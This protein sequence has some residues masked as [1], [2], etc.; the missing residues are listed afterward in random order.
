M[1][2]LPSRDSAQAAPRPGTSSL[3]LATA[4]PD[5][6]PPLA[7]DARADVAVVGAGMAGLVAAYLLAKAGRSVVVLDRF[8]VA[9]GESGH[10]TAHLTRVV[11]TR[12]RDLVRIH[13][14]EAAR[15]AWDG[16]A[17]ATDLVERIAAE[18][19]IACGFVR[20][21]GYLVGV[22]RDDD[23]ILAEEATWARRFG[24]DVEPADPSALPFQG[25][26]VLQFPGQARFHP[27]AFLRGLAR[28]IL[29]LGGRI[30]VGVEVRG[31][32]ASEAGEGLRVRTAQGPTVQAGAVVVASNVPFLDRIGMNP[33]LFPYRSYAIAARVPRGALA[34][35]LVWT[36]SEPGDVYGAYHYLRLEPSGGEDLAILGGEDHKV[37]HAA[38]PEEAWQRLEQRLRR[39]A[40]VPLRVEHRWSGQIIE[41]PDGLPYIGAYPGDPEDVWVATAFSGN[42]MTF[43]ALAGHILAERI[44]G[45]ATAWD[46]AF[47]P[48]RVRGDLGA[49]LEENLD[50]VGGLAR[51]VL[52]ASGAEGPLAPGEGAV[53]SVGGRKVAAYRTPAGELQ[54]CSAVCTHMGCTVAFNRAEGTFDCPCHGSRFAPGGEVLNG[55]A[56]TPLEPVAAAEVEAA[57]QKSRPAGSRGGR[58]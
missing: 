57:L 48:G 39:E 17:F 38:D 37:G 1:A 23:R 18:E 29:A 41:N 3:W 8:G 58:D 26:A 46:E 40:G 14:E 52:P 36:T 13:G 6:Y 11:D 10:T 45:R 16:G 15:A 28:R 42:G 4:A 55:P 27:V 2:P 49:A 54:A 33:K 22:H 20:V 31:I 53:L 21:P 50:T 25:H 12:L 19:G 51:R 56:T 32:E 24:H 7:G 44:L 9:Q 47:D 5:A 34:D 43:G 30:H 35:A